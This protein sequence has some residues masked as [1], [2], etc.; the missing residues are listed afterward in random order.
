MLIFIVAFFDRHIP[1]QT[2]NL[3]I[4][5]PNIKNKKGNIQVK[6]YNND[7]SFPKANEQYRE[8]VFKISDIPGPYLIKDLPKGIYAIAILHDENSDKKCNTN[9]LGI[10]K[11][12]YGFSNNFRPILSA[13]VFKDCEIF[14]TGDTTIQIRLIY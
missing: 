6:I 1:A 4:N 3:V 2:C 14:L 12:G 10:P 7:K 8:A 11:E 13:P 5:V 9:M